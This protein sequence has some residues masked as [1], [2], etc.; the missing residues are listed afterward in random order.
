MVYQRDKESEAV[1]DREQWGYRKQLLELTWRPEDAPFSLNEI[2]FFITFRHPREFCLQPGKYFEWPLQTLEK[3][4]LAA[5]VHGRTAGFVVITPEVRG[6]GVFRA[7]CWVHWLRWEKSTVPP[8][9]FCSL[10]PLWAEFSS[11]IRRE[12][13]TRQLAKQGIASAPS[14][15][16]AIRLPQQY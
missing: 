3:C 8:A 2:S 13:W 15:L 11:R 14:R 12:V 4:S 10:S 9:T 7:H 5:P 16:E 1:G 6:T